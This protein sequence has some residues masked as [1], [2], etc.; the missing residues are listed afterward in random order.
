MMSR[1]IPFFNDTLLLP[2]DIELVYLDNPDRTPDTNGITQVAYIHRS[3]IINKRPWYEIS[4]LTDSSGNRLGETDKLFVGGDK[5]VSNKKYRIIKNRKL[6]YLGDKITATSFASKNNYLKNN[7]SNI[8]PTNNNVIRNTSNNKPLES[9]SK[10]AIG[11][12]IYGLNFPNISYAKALTINNKLV[13]EIDVSQGYDVQDKEHGES[14]TIASLL[15]NRYLDKIIL[16]VKSSNNNVDIEN[17]IVNDNI[18]NLVI[19]WNIV[20]YRT[21]EYISYDTLKTILSDYLVEYFSK[22]NNLKDKRNNEPLIALP[23]NYIMK[24][25]GYN[26]LIADDQYNNGWDRGCV[27]FNYDNSDSFILGKSFY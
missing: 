21:R 27:S 11:S 10:S 8:S 25:M 5:I 20:F 26:G 7:D 2:I 4:L 12:G 1:N 14:I 18:E 24:N 23:I 6:Y 15:T 16:D 9:T 17:F 3:V 13:Y 22:E 19:L